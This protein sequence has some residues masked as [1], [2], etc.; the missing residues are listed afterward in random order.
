MGTRQR[1]Y[2]GYQI[3]TLLF[4]YGTTYMYN[5]VRLLPRRGFCV[6]TFKKPCVFVRRPSG[7]R[8]PPQGFWPV[9]GPKISHFPFDSAILAV[10][11]E[12]PS[13][14]FRTQSDLAGSRSGR[15][16]IITPHQMFQRTI[17]THGRH[18]PSTKVPS[19]PPCP[20]GEI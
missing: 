3:F 16:M 17:I 18:N 14:R 6:E 15:K 5:Y 1:S 20:A 13:A 7:V 11:K 9:F 19:G 2:S 10:Q 8:R 4:T 12:V